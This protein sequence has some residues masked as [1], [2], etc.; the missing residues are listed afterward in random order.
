LLWYQNW[1][2]ELWYFTLSPAGAAL[3]MHC[4]IKGLVYPKMKIMSLMTHPHIIPSL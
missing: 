2:R 4:A 3:N 1:N